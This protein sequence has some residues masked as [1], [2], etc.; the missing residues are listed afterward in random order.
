MTLWDIFHC[1]NLSYAVCNELI[2]NVGCICL[3]IKIA[4]SGGQWWFFWQ[5]ILEIVVTCTNQRI[6]KAKQNLNISS[7]TWYNFMDVIDKTE[8]L[9]FIGLMYL[10]GLQGCVITM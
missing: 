3:K 10:R 7:K 4:L 8:I 2:N 5:K 9:A 1:I 6:E